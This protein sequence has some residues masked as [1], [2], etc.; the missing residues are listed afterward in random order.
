MPTVIPTEI[1]ISDTVT[2]IL[3]GIILIILVFYVIFALMVIRQVDLM[4]R[5]LI[6]RISP[7]LKAAAIFNAGFAIGLI[8]LAWG[9]L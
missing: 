8:L 3:K 2:V 6:T 1:V 7:I 9:L 4:S 5:T